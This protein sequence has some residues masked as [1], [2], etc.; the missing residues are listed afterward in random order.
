MGISYIVVVGFPVTKEN[1]YDTE[2]KYNP[3][4]GEPYENK[5]LVGDLLKHGDV[6]LSS[7]GEHEPYHY[8]GDSVSYTHLTLPTNREV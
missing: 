1:V 5:V 6:V 4:N 2:T 3:D 8:S 7:K